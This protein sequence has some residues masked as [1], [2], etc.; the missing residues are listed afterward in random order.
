M[1]K[2]CYKCIWIIIWNFKSD[3]IGDTGFEVCFDLFFGKITAMAV[4]AGYTVC[5]ILAEAL[6]RL[7]AAFA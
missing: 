4:I 1:I 3:D 5:C 6:E 7:A 2:K